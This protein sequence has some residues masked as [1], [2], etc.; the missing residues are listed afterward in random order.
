M[1]MAF[2]T[3]QAPPSLARLDSSSFSPSNSKSY[4]YQPKPHSRPQARIATKN[5]LQS[6]PVLKCR[7]NPRDRVD[8]V[9]QSHHD[10]QST[11]IPILLHPSVVFPS[12]TLQLQ[13]VEFRYR[14]MMQTLLLQEG[15]SF[16]IIYSSRKDN[17]MADVGCMV[18]IV[19]CD[20]LVNDRF[21]LTCVGGDRFR[22]LEVVRTKPYVIARVQVLK[23]R[24]SPDS[25]N[26]GC[27]MQQVEGHLKDVTML[28]DKLSWK[29]MGDQARQVSRMHSPESFSLV[30]ARLFVEDRSEQQWLLGLDDTAQRLVREERYLQQR[31]KYLA[32]VAAIRDAFG[33]LSCNKKQ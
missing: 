29:L 23:D 11:E 30:V 16:G 18:R 24:D 12:Q 19:Q 22:V 13:T 14:I 7:A 31:S 27:L 3:L 20:K 10:H 4:C 25:S 28:S 1:Y 15:H 5:R 32:A 21:F 6:S 26:L 9:V 33:Q 17:R 2:K 8:E